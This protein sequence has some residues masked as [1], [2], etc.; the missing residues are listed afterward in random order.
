MV[1]DQVQSMLLSMACRQNEF[2]SKF[3][4]LVQRFPQRF[5]S[6]SCRY[7]IHNQYVSPLSDKIQPRKCRYCKENANKLARSLCWRNQNNLL[8]IIDR[9]QAN[10]PPRRVAVI[11]Y[12]AG[13]WMKASKQQI[14]WM[15]RSPQKNRKA[16]AECLAVAYSCKKT[17]AVINLRLH[18]II[19]MQR[20]EQ[21]RM[22]Y[23][24]SLICFLLDLKS[25]LG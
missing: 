25:F 5:A 17:A 8:I 1:L 20:K 9:K 21:H 24:I 7:C 3:V 18:S 16:Y 10:F 2:M 23:F 11:L 4:L 13:L 6:S 22:I 14:I 12:M 15:K 19:F